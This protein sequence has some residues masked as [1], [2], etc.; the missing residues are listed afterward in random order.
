METDLGRLYL[1]EEWIDGLLALVRSFSMVGQYKPAFL[2]LSLLGFIA[3]TFQMVE[4]AHL[5][6]CPIQWFLK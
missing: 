6:M 1:P 5:H 3:A 4:Y 2:Y